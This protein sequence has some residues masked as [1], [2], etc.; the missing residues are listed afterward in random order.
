MTSI[1]DEKT[2][3]CHISVIDNTDRKFMEIELINAKEE[4]EAANI[5]SK[6]GILS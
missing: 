6:T 1:V 4:A 3:Y 5:A 2:A